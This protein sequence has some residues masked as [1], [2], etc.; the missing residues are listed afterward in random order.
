MSPDQIAAILNQR[1]VSLL[2][3]QTATPRQRMLVALAGVPGSG[4]STISSALIRKLS[5]QDAKYIAV[6][7]M[8][9][10]NL[11]Q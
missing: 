9:S 5:G 8:A 4:K 3:R 2:E 6:V 7:P 1:I 11:W 10:I